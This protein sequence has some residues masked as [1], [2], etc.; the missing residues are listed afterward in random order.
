MENLEQGSIKIDNWIVVGFATENTPYELELSTHLLPSLE[1]LNIPHYI[2]IVENKGS[3]LK[4]VAEKPA[5]IYRALEKFPDKNIVVLDAD[6]ELL[7]YPKLF[8]EIPE[9]YDLA[10]HILD[11][12]TWYL[13]NSHIKEVLS[14]T[15]WIRNNERMKTI[16]KLWYDKTIQSYMWEQKILAEVLEQQKINIFDLPLEYC[17]INSL[18]D[19]KEP[20]IKIENPI[21][22]HFQASRQHKRKIR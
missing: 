18:P 6:S 19:G 8:N 5:V 7:E 12:D 20:H 2:E 11:W 4:N 9:E 16:C 3:W 10:L 17:Y 13:N 15:M 21:I 1:K 14:G 22:K